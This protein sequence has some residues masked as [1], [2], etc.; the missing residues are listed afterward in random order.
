MAEPPDP[1]IAAAF[2]P[3]PAAAPGARLFL[4]VP[5]ARAQPAVG[6]PR[7]PGSRRGLAF[8]EIRAYRTGDDAGD[9]RDSGPAEPHGPAAQ[10]NGPLLTV[11]AGREVS[12][13]PR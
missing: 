10:A 3:G 5:A 8:E 12:I 7:Q 11:Q 4:S 1:H 13:S 6:P 2:R 9:R